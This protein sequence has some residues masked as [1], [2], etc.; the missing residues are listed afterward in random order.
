ML[1]CTNLKKK[2]KKEKE[3][4]RKKPDARESNNSAIYGQYSIHE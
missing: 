1:Q 4:K 2:K 3:K